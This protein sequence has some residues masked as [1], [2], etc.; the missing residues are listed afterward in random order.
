MVLSDSA[1]SLTSLQSGHMMLS[2]IGMGGEHH[3]HRLDKLS[4]YAR[5]RRAD[6]LR[7]VDHH[8]EEIVFSLG[9][10]FYLQ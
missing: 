4:D 5:A 6:I 8:D 10:R 2:Y 3:T 1:S 9:V 7:D